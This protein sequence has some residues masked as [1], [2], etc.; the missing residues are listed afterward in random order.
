MSKK[1]YNKLIRDNIPEII[2][3]NGQKAKISTLN[4][5]EYIKALNDK[6]LEEVNEYLTDV[7]TDELADILEVVFALSNTL[8]TSESALLDIRNIK[9]EKNGKFDKRLFL[10]YV[11]S[12]SDNC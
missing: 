5:D 6:L 7:N 10:E 8:N 1:I 2:K 11:E 12:D 4:D 3:A 9:A